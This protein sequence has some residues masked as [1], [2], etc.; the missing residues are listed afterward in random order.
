MDKELKAS[1]LIFYK[2][3]VDQ[4]EKVIDEFIKKAESRCV[5]LIDK[6]GHMVTKRGSTTD[7]DP[8]TLS[9]LV[10]GSFAAT[11]EMAKLLGESEFSVLFHKGQRDHIHLALVADRAILAT[12]FDDQTTIGMVQLY[13]KEAS[14]KIAK[15]F[16]IS[17]KKPRPKDEKIHDNFGTDAQKKLDDFFGE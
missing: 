6:E 1:R 17:E 9:A 2:D 13:N 16:E 3:D 4:I 10:A 11:K 15:I 5:I 8:E 12:V 7:F 14:E